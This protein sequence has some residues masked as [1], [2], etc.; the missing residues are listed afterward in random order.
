[1]AA[2]VILLFLVAVVLAGG[3]LML[4]GWLVLGAVFVAIPAL[5]FGWVMGARIG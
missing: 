5:L 2:L 4:H 3:W 1:M